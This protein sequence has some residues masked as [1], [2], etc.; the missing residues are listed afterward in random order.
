MKNMAQ[1]RFYARFHRLAA[2]AGR[3][4]A[5]LAVLSAMLFSS[6]H[7]SAQETVRLHFPFDKS[8]ISES[9]MQNAAALARLDS[10]MKAG[11]GKEGPVCIVSFSSPEG[12]YAYNTA[13]S[14][15]RARALADY[16]T[17]RYPG[18]GGSI[19][20]NPNAE[21]WPDLRAS[22]LSDNRLTSSEKES[23]LRIIDSSSSPDE[24]EAA[25]RALPVYNSFYR[26]WFRSFRYAEVTFRLSA[27]GQRAPRKEA[28]VFYRLDLTG[29]DPS[30]DENAAALELI[31]SM[32][33]G[34]SPEEISSVVI[35]AAS[36]VDGP[37]AKNDAIAQGRAQSLL[38][39]ILRGRP[40]LEDR[41][42]LVTVPESWDELRWNISNNPGLSAAQ[43]NRLIGII[44]SGAS[45]AEKERQ[46]KASPEWEYLKEYVLP[47]TR[48][49]T[50]V[51]EY[52]EIEAPEVPELP[53]EEIE[54]ETLEEVTAPE[55]LD[56]ASPAVDTLAAPEL[57]RPLFALG[58]NLLYDA[59]IT[60]NVGVE[61]PLGKK[62]SVYADYAFPWWL[63]A[64]N[65]RAYQMLKWDIG[66]R[67]YLSRLSASN[68]LDVLRGHFLGVNLS[69]GYYDIEPRHKGYQG[70]FQLAGLEYGYTWNAGGNW[71]LE[72]VVGA[73]VMG[74]HYRYYEA[75]ADDAHLL[76]QYSGKLYW[77]GP[78]KAGV[79]IKYLFTRRMS[80]R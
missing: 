54:P 8:F 2:F 37:E 73:G 61:V 70:E 59:A 56:T 25:L 34:R 41:V 67:R 4:A 10:L 20:L 5:A 77:L 22:V 31:D 18:V 26:N 21:A 76:Y 38:A 6:T 40:W 46:L 53:V 14:E 23:M 74:S 30:Y 78:T 71:R 13:L 42:T 49:S 19:S 57:R 16:L 55:T 45:A 15:R 35:S 9:Y 27:A 62:W 1:T 33:D 44:D 64:A 66:G 60:P 43:Q 72:A 39:Y 75:S 52:R 68:P 58:T 80:A 69:A 24:K 3:A 65:D 12:D 47:R 17:A 36:S 11:A 29:I 28:Y 48:Y 51:S 63:T 79:S 7:A 50:M 32:L